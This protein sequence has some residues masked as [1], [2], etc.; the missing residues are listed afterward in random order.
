[1]EISVNGK[2][3]RVNQKPG[4]Y[5]VVAREWKNGDKIALK[6]PF[7]L[8]T[9]AMPDNPNRVAIMYGPLVL[10]GVL[11]QIES[12]MYRDALYV[13]VLL[14]KGKE[15]TDC[16]TPV[17]GEANTFVTTGIGRPRDIKLKPFY[18][19]HDVRYSV[20]WDVFDEKGWEMAK[21][22]YAKDRE[23]NNRMEEMTVDFLQPGE[24]QS[25]RDHQ[26]SELNSSVGELKNRKFREVGNGWFS[27]TMGVYQ[28]QPMALVIDYRGG[29]TGLKT[30]DILVNDRIIATEDQ[31]VFKEEIF[32]SIQYEIPDNLTFDQSSITVKFVPHT[33][34][35]TGPIFG[36]RTIRR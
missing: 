10:A 24:M 17:I 21:N 9:E 7:S 18:S 29:S 15:L 34:N 31:A 14:L 36:V 1:M 2:L 28:G 19:T 22:D 25:E 16:I 35:S 3:K 5:I 32:K 8:H 13:P 20:Y 6:L 27:C 26:F 23:A 11:G 30:F 33:G 12:N 4:S